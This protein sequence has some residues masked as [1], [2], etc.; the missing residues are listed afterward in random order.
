[1]NCSFRGNEYFCHHRKKKKV[2]SLNRACTWL[3]EIQAPLFSKHNKVSK[4]YTNEHLRFEAIQIVCSLHAKQV[5]NWSYGAKKS[6]RVKYELSRFL[7][8]AIGHSQLFLYESYWGGQMCWLARTDRLQFTQKL[9]WTDW[10]CAF[11]SI[12]EHRSFRRIWVKRALL[13]VLP[14]CAFLTFTVLWIVSAASPFT[15][16]RFSILSNSERKW[17]RIVVF[18]IGRAWLHALYL[19]CY[20]AMRHLSLLSFIPFLNIIKM[21][22]VYGIEGTLQWLYRSKNE[23]D[24]VPQSKFQLRNKS[25]K[26]WNIK[27]VIKITTKKNKFCFHPLLAT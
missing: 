5:A 6:L 7:Y 11:R 3:L 20:V 18:K 27:S 21:G 4:G 22:L 15:I 1:M 23:D 9:L 13:S 24:W 16:P 12:L 10:S 17:D 19:T 8:R 2:S 26:T 25:R 14:T